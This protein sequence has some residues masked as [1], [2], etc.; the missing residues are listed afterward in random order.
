MHCPYCRQPLRE[1]S[2]ECPGCRLTL[3]RAAALLG[4]VPPLAAGIADPE[5]LLSK[6]E[7]RRLARRIAAF[8]RRF[9]QLRFQFLA[10]RFALGLPFELHVFWMFNRAR[11]IPDGETGGDNRAI[12]LVLDPELGKTSLMLGYGLEPL[13]EPA[14]LD[15]I[16]EGAEADFARRQWSKGVTRVLADLDALLAD[17]ATALERAFRPRPLLGEA[18]HY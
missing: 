2:P 18:G 11:F 3:D 6:S 10:N 13:I 17:T 15:A 16:L 9:P 7:R 5:G 14:R 1:D 12:L 8:E 4:P